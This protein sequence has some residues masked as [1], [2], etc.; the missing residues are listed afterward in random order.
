[1]KKFTYGLGQKIQTKSSSLWSGNFILVR[2]KDERRLL[3]PH[4]KGVYASLNT[5]GEVQVLNETST[6]DVHERLHTPVCIYGQIP[7]VA[8]GCILG[9]G[10]CYRTAQEYLIIPDI[11]RYNKKIKKGRG[12][13]KVIL[14]F[15]Y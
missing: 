1:M 14:L 3:G 11:I 12:L 4:A 9:K 5:L 15:K 10:L 6:G 13:K 8:L 7:T 2:R